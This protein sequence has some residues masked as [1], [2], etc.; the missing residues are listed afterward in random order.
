MN[1]C[2]HR[3]GL[4]AR[5]NRLTEV[6]HCQQR[7]FCTLDASQLTLAGGE[8]MPACSS[9]SQFE[10]RGN[11]VSA[12]CLAYDLPRRQVILEEAVESFARQTFAS[13]ELIIV[14][15][16]P[17][18]VIECD[19]PRVRVI[20]VPPCATLGEKYNAGIEAARGNLIC[21]WDDDDISLPWRMSLSV[22]LLGNADYFNPKAYW[23]DYD[24][25]LM[26][27][28]RTGYA[29]N[30]G[31]FRKSAW[32]KVGRYKPLPDNSQ[33]AVMDAALQ[34][35]VPT[36]LGS[37]RIEQTAYIYRW[38]NGLHHGS[39]G[40]LPQKPMGT[41]TF[42]LR[43]HWEKN[44]TRQSVSLRP[45]AIPCWL[46]NRDALAVRPMVEHL[47][48]C[49]DVGPITIVDCD[50]TYQPLL[51][52]YDNECPVQVIRAENLGNQAPWRFL[53]TSTDYL[54]S[55]AD[56]DL[57]TVPRDFATKLRRALDRFPGLVK[58]GLS[59]VI[60][61]LPEESPIRDRVVA[62]ESQFWTKPLDGEH[63]DAAVDTT[64]AMY[65][66]GTGW[67]GYSPAVRL[68]P[69]YAARHVPWYLTPANTSEDWQHYFSR[70]NPTGIVWGP[71]LA[72]QLARKCPDALEEM[73]VRV[74]DTESDI[75]QHCTALKRLASQAG[76]VVEFGM[77]QGVST[78]ALLAGQPQ[79][80]FTVDLY[81]DPIAETLKANAGATT[82]R[83]VQSS[84]LTLEPIPCDLLFIDTLHTRD[85]L[86]AELKRHAK[87]CR[88]RI[89]LHDTHTFG[90]QGEH[91][92]PGLVPAIREFLAENPEWFV[93]SHVATNNGFTVLSRAEEDRPDKTWDLFVSRSGP[94]LSIG[95]ACYRDWP[96]VWATIQS[97]RVHHTDCLR[98][99][100]IIV[101]DNDPQG[102]P[103]SNDEGSHSAKC[104][105]LCERIGARYEHFTKV[106]GTAA[107]KGR[108]FDLA[109][110][111]AVLVI[112]CHVLLPTGVVRRLIEWFNTHPGS[113]DLWQG[114]CIGDGGIDDLVG[115]HFTPKWG[116]LMY[117]QWAVNDRAFQCDDPFEIE[118]QGCGQFACRKEAWPGFHPLLRGF[119]PEEF[120]LH[121]RIRRNG[122]RCYCLPWLKW[123]HRFGNPDGTRPPGLHPEERL[124]GHLITY[125]DTGAPCLEIMRR[126]FV[127]E[128]KAVTTEQFDRVLEQ[129]RREFSAAESPQEVRH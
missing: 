61:D 5:L 24:G 88:H 111:P 104:R 118:M 120:H 112:D 60:D 51:N 53:D 45:A 66:A 70:L 82:F 72:T 68:A 106:A 93:M 119:G 84:T 129:T 10:P 128:A 122:G 117:G 48:T 8:P 29:H 35:Q 21:S 78:T 46:T 108:I 115:T 125:F 57:A 44:Y 54:V 77:R 124:R 27:E 127:E 79:Q 102:Q 42:R 43:P 36:V 16:T 73:F 86:Q 15:D 109:T 116:S 3:R 74:R 28:V 62:H 94:K 81:H 126:H 69:P 26:H 89:A 65:R 23:V 30:A 18:L 87:A 19:L 41:G 9:C 76:V 38:G 40:P 71:A 90:E 6:Y 121:Q 50:S 80:L 107:A 4:H 123:C 33:D 20:N 95:M 2:Q 31:I 17:G 39:A 97:L 22:E 55:D 99:I 96:G 105:G 14:N 1:V 7:Q 67:G 58:A 49:D 12:I 103:Y 100:E 52:W 47:I 113:K 32:E 13:R 98:E 92:E 114:P 75:N 85:Q 101:V 37:G 59:L 25:N 64:L 56:L 63:Y 11:L 91:G 83:F 110:A 34:S